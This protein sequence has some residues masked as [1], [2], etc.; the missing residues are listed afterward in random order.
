MSENNKKDNKID[1]IDLSSLTNSEF[2]KEL[3]K[4]LRKVN[5]TKKE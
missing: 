4:E 3:A 2:K 1:K 5:E